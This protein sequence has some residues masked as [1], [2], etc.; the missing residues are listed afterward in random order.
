MTSGAFTYLGMYLEINK[1][2]RYSIDM[3]EYVENTVKE[4]FGEV[5]LTKVPGVPTGK[6]Q[7]E[8]KES[9][10]LSKKKW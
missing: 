3:Q 1:R 2:G 10:P 7:F 9:K 6:D 4:H 8:V 5:K